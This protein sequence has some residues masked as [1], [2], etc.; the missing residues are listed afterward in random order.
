MVADIILSFLVLALSSITFYQNML[1]LYYYTSGWKRCLNALFVENDVWIL[2]PPATS[3]DESWKGDDGD[4]H[5]S[6][7]DWWSPVRCHVAEKPSFSHCVFI[8]PVCR[9]KT[10]CQRAPLPMI[11]WDIRGSQKARILLKR[12]STQCTS[13]PKKRRHFGG[14]SPVA[15]WCEHEPTIRAFGVHF[16]IVSNRAFNP[17][18]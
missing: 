18:Q 12:G 2:S 4:D 1:R 16:F 8:V 3:L 13:M 17:S 5:L 9:L 6:H 15:Q 14:D 11:Y 10:D 7:L